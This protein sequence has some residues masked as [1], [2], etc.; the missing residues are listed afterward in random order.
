MGHSPKALAQLSPPDPVPVSR[1]TPVPLYRPQVRGHTF[2]GV[3]P[4]P[5]G[6]ADPSWG[7][8]SGLTLPFLL[9][10][11]PYQE[12]GLIPCQ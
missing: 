2:L 6:L 8:L 11:C 12:P 10:S 1:L 4:L 5:Q 3:H 9:S 7:T